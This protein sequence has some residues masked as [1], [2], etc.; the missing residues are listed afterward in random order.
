MYIFEG[1]G[2]GATWSLLLEALHNQGVYVTTQNSQ[3]AGNIRSNTLQRMCEQEVIS[4]DG[5]AY[6]EENIFTL[7]EWKKSERRGRE[8]KVYF[9][10]AM[11]L[12]TSTLIDELGTVPEGIALGNDELQV[13]H[14]KQVREI[15]N[16]FVQNS[17]E[18]FGRDS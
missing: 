13:F 10:V 2:K 4:I 11:I 5:K 9:D 7:D 17:R 3:G 15:K 18:Y 8:T 16:T 12:I 14:P 1:R 6:L